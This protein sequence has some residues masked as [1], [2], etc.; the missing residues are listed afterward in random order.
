[1]SRKR[2]GNLNKK[3]KGRR[4]AGKRKVF[5]IV[6]L[7]LTAGTGFF[8]AKKRSRKIADKLQLWKYDPC[9]KRQVQ[10]KEEK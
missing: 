2:G 5:K 8:Y 3:R 7:V 4:K 9:V 1:L 10:F 6:K